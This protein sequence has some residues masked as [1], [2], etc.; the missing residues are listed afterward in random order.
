LIGI[1]S[2]IDEV[3]PLYNIITVE[4]QYDWVLGPAEIRLAY[5]SVVEWNPI[6]LNSVGNMKQFSE[7][8]LNMATDFTDSVI[9][10][11]T[12]LSPSWSDVTFSGNS[13]GD[14]GLFAWGEIPWG[15]ET[16]TITCHRTY[17]P[18]DKQRGNVL[19]VKYTTNT[20]YTT[21]EVSGIELT[22]RGST[23]R[24]GRR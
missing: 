22:Y 9:S 13:A 3:D 16:D 6:H 7:A 4:D 21:W 8:V 12:D 19:M 18:R 14:W 17:V 1:F 5:Q 24:S 15:G 20:A 2:L 10:F 11:K 23:K